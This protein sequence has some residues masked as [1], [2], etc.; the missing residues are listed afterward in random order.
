MQPSNRLSVPD[1]IERFRAYKQANPC[2]GALHIVLD[3]GNVKNKDVEFCAEDA[4]ERGDAEG[5]EL[6]LLLLQ[7][8]TT[9]RHKLRNI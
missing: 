4:L 9:Q 3:D 7:M 5:H 1:V 8:S 2:W 6:A